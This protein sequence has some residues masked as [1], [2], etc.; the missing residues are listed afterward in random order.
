VVLRLST[1]DMFFLRHIDKVTPNFILLG[2][3][4]IEVST[5]KSTLC[6]TINI[7]EH[8]HNSTMQDIY[9]INNDIHC[10]IKWDNSYALSY[11]LM[12]KRDRW[13]ELL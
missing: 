10:N 1:C 8:P 3:H 4:V 9:L 13:I 6:L 5:K 7:E 11:P 12:W 2:L